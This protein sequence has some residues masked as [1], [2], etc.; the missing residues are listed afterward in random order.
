[1]AIDI[2]MATIT[3]VS[4]RVAPN[5]ISTVNIKNK[6]DMDRNKRKATVIAIILK[7]YRHRISPKAMAIGPYHL[8]SLLIVS[9][10]FC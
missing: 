6:A 8:L 1:M 3:F 2:I 5:T 10:A 7:P 4:V 9:I